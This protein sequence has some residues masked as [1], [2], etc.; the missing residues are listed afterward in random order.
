[1]YIHILFIGIYTVQI[2]LTKTPLVYGTTKK[3]IILIW[4]VYCCIYP[5]YAGYIFIYIP[6]MRDIYKYIS[7]GIYIF[8][9]I[10][11]NPLNGIYIIY[12]VL[13]R[14]ICNNIPPKPRHFF[15]LGYNIPPQPRHFSPSA[16]GLGRKMPRFRG[17]IV[18]RTK[19][20]PG[21]GGILL[22][23]PLSSTV[24][25]LHIYIKKCPDKFLVG[26]KIWTSWGSG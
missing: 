23:I 26:L 11:E 3:Y 13:Y 19:K 8:T 1:M 18:P 16:C 4:G 24:Y 14:G 22:H 9:Y 21:F 10:P 2:F 20:C 7:L 12:T 15:V 5:S 6:H 25:T 17:Y